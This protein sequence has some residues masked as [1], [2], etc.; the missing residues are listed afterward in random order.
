MVIVEAVKRCYSVK[1]HRRGPNRARL[2]GPFQ[3]LFEITGDRS[4]LHG[5]IRSNVITLAVCIAT[6]CPDVRLLVMTEVSLM[7][8][9]TGHYETGQVSTGRQRM[10]QLVYK[11]TVQVGGQGLILPTAD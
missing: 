8:D 10:E 5:L 9:V 6:I 11:A 1:G 3:A 7:Q 4:I 2:G